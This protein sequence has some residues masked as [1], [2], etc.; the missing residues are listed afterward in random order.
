MS[1]RTTPTGRQLS[2]L[3]SRSDKRKKT[4]K[5][6]SGSSPGEAGPSNKDIWRALSTLSDAVSQFQ[7]GLDSLKGEM[8]KGLDDIMAKIEEQPPPAPASTA[9]TPTKVPSRLSRKVREIHNGLGD[10]EFKGAE[11]FKSD[12]N[13]AVTKLIER[14]LRDDPETGEQWHASHITK[15]CKNYHDTIRRREKSIALGKD[16]A[17]KKER[18]RTNRRTRL[19]DR[20]KLAGKAVLSRAEQEFLEGAKACLMSEEETDTEDCDRWLVKQP[21]WRSRKLEKILNKCKQAME[22]KAKSRRATPR[23]P[24]DL[25]SSEA[26][27]TKV[28]RAYVRSRSE[29]EAAGGSQVE[30]EEIEDGDEARS[31]RDNENTGGESDMGSDSEGSDVEKEQTVRGKR[32]RDEENVQEEVNIVRR[33]RGRSSRIMIQDEDDTDDDLE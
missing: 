30:T 10:M 4:P 2:G 22:K 14:A 3:L 19:F 26:T 1:H 7:G 17:Q 24:S 5:D 25:P 21:S 15:S 27:P 23:I 6:S 28:G 32:V 8:K 33:K 31:E 20:R 16:E 9:A 11:T 12:H 18:K 13:R 29:E